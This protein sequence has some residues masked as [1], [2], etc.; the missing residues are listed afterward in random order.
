M[1]PPC[2]AS[3]ATARATSRPPYACP[4]IVSSYRIRARVEVAGTEKFVARV[5]VWTSDNALVG[6][7]VATTKC[8]P[9]SLEEARR[10]CYELVKDVSR[11]LEAEGHSIQS[12]EIDVS[13]RYP[14]G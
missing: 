2:C 14:H 12:V 9:C 7:E 10:G 3:P 13:V 4:E 6:D 5:C 1:S 8:E 11:K